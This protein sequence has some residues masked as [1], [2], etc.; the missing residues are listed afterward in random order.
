MEVLR[1]AGISAHG[2]DLSDESIALCRSKNLSA[3]KAD[4][5]AYLDALPTSY[6]DG[7]VSCQVVEHLPPERVPE[8]V[9]L[10]HE[11]LKKGGILALETPNP[12][13]LAIF[14]T[15]FYLDPTHQRPIP[16]ALL[17]FY[18]EEAGFGRIEVVRLSPAMETIPSVAALPEEFRNQF[19]GAMD[20]AIFGTKL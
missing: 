17:A 18:I 12:E 15:H 7:I 5:F 9:R 4:L 2:V 16:P 10:A 13:C 14:A 20:Y 19:F 1:G 3:E 8:L 6:L 11:K